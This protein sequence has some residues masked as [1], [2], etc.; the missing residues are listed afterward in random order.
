MALPT[1]SKTW[2]FK[3]NQYLPAGTD[4]PTTFKAIFYN[5]KNSLVSATGWTDS[6]GSPVV[7]AH[8]WQVISSSDASFADLTDRWGGPANIVV[9]GANCSW[10]VLRQPAINTLYEIGLFVGTGV[11]YNVSTLRVCMLAGF[12]T[13]GL[14]TTALP[15]PNGS[16]YNT[17]TSAAAIDGQASA[18]DLTLHY[19]MSTDG[20]CTYVFGCYANAVTLTWLFT[21][22]KNPVTG[23]TYPFIECGTA[24]NANYTNLVSGTYMVGRVPGINMPMYCTTE[25]YAGSVLG[26]S[27]MQP[28]AISG[29][30][31]M[32]PIGLV[33]DTP[34][35]RG[36]HGELYDLWF[37][38]S[39][40]KIGDTLPNTGNRTFAIMGNLLVPWNNSTMLTM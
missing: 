40:V 18:H 29:E 19:M 38:P 1:L 17:P 23:W 7:N 25:G 5:L 4:Q 15:T 31:A 2:I 35:C 11:N 39:G 13:T 12:Q 6:T 20:E 36:R 30:W 33:S 26:Q 3:T 22:V 28:N 9:S 27:I 10:I 37:A 16:E 24:M 8:P 21:K 14:V 32:T 34:G